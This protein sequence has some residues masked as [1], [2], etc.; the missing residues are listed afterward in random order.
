MVGLS[1]DP[2]R[3]SHFAA[4]YMLAEGYDL[5]PVNPREQEILGQ[6]GYASLRDIPEPVDIVDVFRE[7]A[8]VPR[9]RRGGDRDR[10]E[11]PLDAAWRHQRG[12]GASARARPGWKS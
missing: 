5:I 9:D 2:L 4:I 12:G 8:A 10:R 11:G 7:P 6:R 1:S 3:P